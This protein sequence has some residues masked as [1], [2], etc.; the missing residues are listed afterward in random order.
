MPDWRIA[1]ELALRLREDFDLATVQEVQDEIARVAPAFAGVDATLLG[2][3]RDGAVLPI[4]DHPDELVLGPLSIA[5]TGLSWE[6]IAPGGTDADVPVPEE[7][8]TAPGDGADPATD[9]ATADDEVATDEDLGAAVP[10]LHRFTAEVP[11][12]AAPARDAYALRLVSSRVLYDGGVLVGLT[13][14][15]GSLVRPATLWVHPSDRDRVGVGEG[16]RVRVTSAAGSLDLPMG[17][18]PGVAVGTAVLDWNL[19]GGTAGALV[20]A[21]ASVTDLRVESIR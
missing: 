18:D 10:A 14:A 20:D 16:E 8:P 11:A 2:R 17:A 9:D 1:S 15:F 12:P 19:P 13:P 5:V 4:A 7:T 21:A 3:A 6:P